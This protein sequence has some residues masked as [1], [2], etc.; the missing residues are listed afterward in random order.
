MRMSGME[1]SWVA[2]GLVEMLETAGPA[3]AVRG[4][5]ALGKFFVRHDDLRGLA[6]FEELDGDQRLFRPAVRR[7]PGEHQ[8]FRPVD[9]AIHARMRNRAGLALHHDLVAP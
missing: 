1:I 6:G 8:S 4:A 2:T 9:D 3:A 5:R 7:V